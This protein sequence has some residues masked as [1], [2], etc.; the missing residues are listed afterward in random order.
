MAKAIS[1][2][3]EAIRLEPGEVRGYVNRA[4]AYVGK[5]EPDKAVADLTEAI[6]RQPKLAEAYGHR[7]WLYQQKGDFQ[8][9][10]A[11]LDALIDSSPPRATTKSA[12][13]LGFSAATTTAASRTS[14]RP[15]A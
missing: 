3:T 8:K 12:A 5:G 9:A 4:Y 1:D 15:S 13:W 10:I 14:R 11:D 6:R 7:G 2:L